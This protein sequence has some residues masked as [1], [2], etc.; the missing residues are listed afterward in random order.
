MFP[1]TLGLYILCI[2]VY[3]PSFLLAKLAWQ[4]RREHVLPGVALDRVAIV[5]ALE[6]VEHT[7]LHGGRK[8]LRVGLDVFVDA[9]HLWPE[10]EPG[11]RAGAGGPT[12]WGRINTTHAGNFHE[13]SCQAIGE[14]QQSAVP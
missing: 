12:Q 5:L 13:D 10:A 9:R 11:E 6:N 2:N 4:M 1:R 7:R 3:P 8:V 14:N